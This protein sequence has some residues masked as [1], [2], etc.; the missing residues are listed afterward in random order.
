MYSPSIAL[1]GF[2]AGEPLSLL[3]RVLDI[4]DQVERLLGQ[5]VALA[6]EDLLEAADRLLARHV[7]AG[8]IGERLGNVHR[9]REEAL[10]PARARDH[11]FV[12]G[13]QLVHPEDRD[14]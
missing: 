4:A 14:D 1:A 11:G 3:A 12:F 8:Q 10:Y 5:I 13:R 6:V 2:A 9:L 7:F